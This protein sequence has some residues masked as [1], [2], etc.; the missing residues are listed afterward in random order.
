M[1]NRTAKRFDIIIKLRGDNVY[2]L[3]FNDIWVCS[4]GNYDKALDVAK[5]LIG[6]DLMKDPN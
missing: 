6:M 3:Y 2:D 1:N 4:C 5:E